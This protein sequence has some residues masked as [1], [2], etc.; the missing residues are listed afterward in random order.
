MEVGLTQTEVHA[1]PV[2]LVI[3]AFVGLVL[4]VPSWR[5]KVFGR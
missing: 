2:W 3:V 5:Q 1:F 4:I